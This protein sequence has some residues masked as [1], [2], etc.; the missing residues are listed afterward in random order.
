LATQRE[1]VLSYRDRATDI[2]SFVVH[3]EGDVVRVHGRV[4]SRH[5]G[6][7]N[8]AAKTRMAMEM[9]ARELTRAGS[10]MSCVLRC[11]V[12]LSDM[13]RWE[14]FDGVFVSYF[15]HDRLPVYSVVEAM[16]GEDELEIECVARMP[17]RKKG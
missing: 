14:E 7:N 4:N 8:I 16:E 15:D 11:T 6:E 9:I 1:I 13:S 10:N 17:A 3:R 5:D 2:E 12:I